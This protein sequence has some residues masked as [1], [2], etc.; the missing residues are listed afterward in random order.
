MLKEDEVLSAISEA[1]C[2]C[3]YF[4]NQNPENEIAAEV[5]K[6]IRES[7]EKF[8]AMSWSFDKE[9]TKKAREFWGIKDSVNDSE[10]WTFLKLL[11]QEGHAVAVKALIDLN[12][13]YKQ[14]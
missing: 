2:A 10:V 1:E 14:W 5:H 9:T 3:Y 4:K 6:A 13:S 11:Q 8:Y 7:L 12:M